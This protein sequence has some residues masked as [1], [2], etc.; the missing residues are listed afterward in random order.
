M[1]KT[2]SIILALAM[3]LALSVSALAVDLVPNSGASSQNVTASY[4]AHTDAP[5]AT[6]YYVTIAWVA[7][8]NDI[9]YSEGVTT[10]VW[11]A[12]NTKFDAGTLTGKGWTGTAQYTI[13]VTNQSN[14]AIAASA[15]WAPAAGITCAATVGSDLALNRADVDG[16]NAVLTPAADLAGNA[17]S[18]TITV[19]VATPTAGTIAADGALVGTITVAISHA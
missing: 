15:S 19:D 16:S 3:V 14:D 17:Q 10:Y 6:A 2:L 5:V 8:N 11:D 18:D 13:T 7:N 12:A 9:A 1:K 4:T